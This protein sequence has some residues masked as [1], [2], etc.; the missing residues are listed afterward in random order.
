MLG[1]DNPPANVHCPAFGQRIE[2]YSEVSTTVGT[3]EARDIF[4]KSEL[5]KL[6]I[7]GLP[8]VADDPHELKEEAR[9][10]RLETAA[11]TSNAQILARKSADDDVR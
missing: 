7:R 8:Y 4:D 5:W 6:T 2:E 3:K 11:L 1:V 9:S 10:F